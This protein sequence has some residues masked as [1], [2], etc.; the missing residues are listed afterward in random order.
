MCWLVTTVIETDVYADRSPQIAIITGYKAT[1]AVG[2]LTTHSQFSC[3]CC[4]F[5]TN[6]HFNQ[7]LCTINC[8]VPS[9]DSMTLIYN[10]FILLCWVASSHT[11]AVPSL[12][13]QYDCNAAHLPAQGIVQL[14]LSSAPDCD[15]IY[16]LWVA[17]GTILMPSIWDWTRKQGWNQRFHCSSIRDVF[18]MMA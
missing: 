17:L 12:N 10:Q 1:L 5:S 18:G 7:L 11:R 2:F 14:N 15:N 9:A 16:V 3:Q 13:Q 6:L 4:S 8:F